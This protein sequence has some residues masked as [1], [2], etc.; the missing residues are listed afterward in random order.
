MLCFEEFLL[1]FRLFCQ[2]LIASD[3]NSNLGTLSTFIKHYFCL[4]LFLLRKQRVVSNSLRYLVDEVDKARSTTIPVLEPRECMQL[5]FSVLVKALHCWV[6]RV[7]VI[8]LARVSHP[9][10]DILH[11]VKNIVP[12]VVRHINI[13]VVLIL[14]HL[15]ALESCIPHSYAW[16]PNSDEVVHE[17]KANVHS[18]DNKRSNERTELS[19][20]FRSTKCIDSY[21][22]HQESDDKNQDKVVLAVVVGR[23]AW[24][25]CVEIAETQEKEQI[26]H[27]AKRPSQ[28]EPKI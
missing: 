13:A 11:S 19:F 12:A 7:S 2:C 27:R 9:T 6:V 8:V 21:E 5:G 20:K 1:L 26:M 14:N 17:G 23:A 15:R 10:W 3:C 28:S 22:I 24:C 4:C 16:I 25:I 18:A